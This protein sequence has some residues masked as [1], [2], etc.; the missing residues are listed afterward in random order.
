MKK[1][2]MFITLIVLLVAPLLVMYWAVQRHVEYLV[3]DDGAK[4]QIPLEIVRNKDCKEYY[5][6]LDAQPTLSAPADNC[7]WH[8]AQ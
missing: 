8:K 5:E 1:L 3:L 4:I 2:F 6:W 7:P